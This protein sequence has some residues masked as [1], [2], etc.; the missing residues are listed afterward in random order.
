MVVGRLCGCVLPS[1]SLVAAQRKERRGHRVRGVALV[2]VGDLRSSHPSHA[3]LDALAFHQL[4]VGDVV[5]VLL[6]L[7]T[8]VFA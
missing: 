8:A 5:V 6:L 7:L 3:S 2:A 1:R 4:V